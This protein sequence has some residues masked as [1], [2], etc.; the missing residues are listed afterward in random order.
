[1]CKLL[2]FSMLL[3]L[4]SPYLSALNDRYL[5][6]TLSRAF[7]VFC[8]NI[9]SSI[10]RFV[11]SSIGRIKSAPNQL[12]GCFWSSGAGVP[13][14]DA[15]PHTGKVVSHRKFL[16]LL[17]GSRARAQPTPG[18]RIPHIIYQSMLFGPRM[19]LLRVANKKILFG[20]LFPQTPSFLGWNRDF[21]L[22]CLVE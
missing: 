20:K 17:F 10:L 22:K 7:S 8:S 18:A 4:F 16:L 12:W 15:Y 1:M 5:A 2:Y 3:A 9:V 13:L 19:C 21:Q 6:H 11:W 14:T